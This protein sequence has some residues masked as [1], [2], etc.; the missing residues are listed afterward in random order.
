M[1]K[2]RFNWWPFALNM[3][4]DYP[5]RVQELKDLRQQNVTA[6]I[7]GMPRGGGA[8]R[9]TEGIALR[10]LPPQEQ[11]EY[12]AV[13]NALRRTE[14]MANAKWRRDVV[15]LTIWKGYTIRGVA[16]M[17]DGL[18][19]ATVERYRRHFI[20]LVGRY[21]GFMTEAEYLAELKR[22]NKGR[23]SKSHDQKTV[24]S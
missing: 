20:L 7:S 17:I 4:R 6:D 18:S 23:K 10:Q 5:A 11:R 9:T 12:E 21:Y 22:D 15:K 14:T 2:E 19:D 13:H 3:I 16:A 1:S 8:S 24:L